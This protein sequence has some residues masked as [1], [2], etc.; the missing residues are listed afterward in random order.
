V[1]KLLTEFEAI[2]SFFTTLLADDL[3]F[4]CSYGLNN[5]ENVQKGKECASASLHNVKSA[6]KQQ[7]L[8]NKQVNLSSV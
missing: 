7:G 6:A 3:L 1:D 5:V 8:N 2:S 4:K